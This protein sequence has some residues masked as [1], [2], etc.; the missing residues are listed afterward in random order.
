MVK[1][2]SSVLFL[3]IPQLYKHW[4]SVQIETPSIYSDYAFN[5]IIGLLF[6]DSDN[7]TPGKML[8]KLI[9]FSFCKEK[10]SSKAFVLG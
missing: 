7:E 8:Q 1:I 9:V 10:H 2:F 6:K 3:D 4:P 5:S